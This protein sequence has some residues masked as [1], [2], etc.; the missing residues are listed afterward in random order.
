MI[1]CQIKASKIECLAKFE[2]LA[3][4]VK[5]LQFGMQGEQVWFNSCSHQAADL[6]LVPKVRKTAV[7]PCL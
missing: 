7:G 6:G 5:A 1:T 2:C 3:D 4:L